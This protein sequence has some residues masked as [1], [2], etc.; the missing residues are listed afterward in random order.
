[1]GNGIMQLLQS[2]GVNLPGMEDPEEEARRMAEMEAAQ[3]IPPPAVGQEIVVTG[4]N[5]NNPNAQDQ[6]LAPNAGPADMPPAAPLPSL[7]NRE[8]IQRSI[9]AGK[10]VPQREGKFGIKGTLRDILGTVSDAFLVQSGNKA[11]YAPQ[12][13]NERRAN[14]MAGMTSN[15]GNTVERLAGAGF[16]DDA[17]G[18]YREMGVQDQR[19]A[20]AKN[21]QATVDANVRKEGAKNYEDGTKLMAQAAAAIEANPALFGTVSKRME[22][23]KEMY[24]LGDEFEILDPAVAPKGYYAGMATSGTPAS[25][26]ANINA[27]APTKEA[28]IS[29]G[30]RRAATGER[31]AA[32]SERR[33]AA[34]ELAASRAK[35]T[36]PTNASMAQP[37]L[38]KEARGETLTAGEL[39]KLDRL[40]PPPARNRRS[41]G[42]ST[43]TP[44]SPSKFK[45]VS[46]N[47]KPI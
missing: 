13:E 5:P 22:Q 28:N 34:A 44:A 46:I 39:K 19:D 40:A 9:D 4:A 7:S 1:M 37:L 43:A 14:A 10:D 6:Y 42:A 33:A 3:G 8:H 2:V 23:I 24:G 47:G 29:Q 11:V 16:G 30:E 17:S 41:R 35:P 21:Q 36:N 18:L 12:L 26:V 27:N 45:T 15:I 32:T 38:D 31:N 25:T 20:T